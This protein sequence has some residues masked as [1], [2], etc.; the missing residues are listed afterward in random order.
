LEIAA[1]AAGGL[2]A[3]YA[4]VFLA[5]RPLDLGL[6]LI[7]LLALPPLI[8]GLWP[9]QMADFYQT[10]FGRA[11]KVM[12]WIGYGLFGVSFAIVASII[13]GFAADP[14]DPGA[15]AVLVLGA[16]LWGS[17]PS[18]TLTRRL[19]T[20]LVYARANPQALIVVSGG[21]GPDEERTEASAMAEYLEDHGIDPGRI[22]Q[23]G[24]SYSTYDNFAL[25]KALLDQRLSPGYRVVFVTSDFHI[26]RASRLARAEGMSAQG[27]ASASVPWYL[28]MYYVREYLVILKYW[29]FGSS[30]LPWLSRIF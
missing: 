2:L 8:W 21:Q 27:L 19:D 29:I 18:P 10:A 3:L 13:A 28:P 20:A 15:D 22:L 16:G 24:A 14:P 25:S 6:W 1:A 23:E 12:L 11:V 4:L 7:L 26:Y 9:R 30:S 17:E 5:R